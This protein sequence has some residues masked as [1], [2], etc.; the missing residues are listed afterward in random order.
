MIYY[1]NEII[2]LWTGDNNLTTKVIPIIKYMSIGNFFFILS[3]IIMNFFQGIGK[4]KF[5]TY[6]LT[7]MCIIYFSLMLIFIEN[8]NIIGVAYLWIIVSFLLF[9]ATK[10]YFKFKSSKFNINLNLIYLILP[11]F[12]S[13][14]I[15]FIFIYIFNF[16]EIS[17]KNIFIFLLIII[18]TSIVTISTSYRLRKIIYNVITKL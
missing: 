18:I 11:L 12:T 16:L 8:F 4:T 6:S 14:I 2:L 10:I 13:M 15:P 3:N 5:M 7:I 17:H 9:S 1:G